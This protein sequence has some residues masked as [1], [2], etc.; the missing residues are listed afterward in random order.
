M[1]V[2]Q[3]ISLTMLRAY[4]LTQVPESKT[5]VFE[6]RNE[7]EDDR[8]RS[9]LGPR[10]RF[11]DEHTREDRTRVSR[12]ALS[13]LQTHLALSRIA[14]TG[15]GVFLWL[16]I[17][18]FFEQ[19]FGTKYTI[20]QTA[21][22]YLLSQT[23]TC[24]TAPLA[25]ESVRAGLNRTVAWSICCLVAALLFLAG[26]LGGYFGPML[27]GGLIGFAILYGVFSAL[28]WLPYTAGERSDLADLAGI[29]V[30]I[31]PFIVGLW[32]SVG[33][34]EAPRIL[35]GAAAIAALSLMPLT[36]LSEVKEFFPW[37][38]RETFGE[39]FD[40]T[41]RRMVTLSFADG[42]ESA[43]FFFVW[44][45]VIFELFWD[46]FSLVGA[47]ASIL[48]IIV[49]ALRVVFREWHKPRLFES[50][51]PSRILIGVSS[52]VLR[53]SAVSFFTIILVDIYGSMSSDKKLYS[54]FDR[55]SRADGGYYLD[56]R[57]L[58]KELAT[59][60]GRIVAI[61]LFW[62]LLNAFTI[63]TSVILMFLFGALVSIL[64][65]SSGGAE[66]PFV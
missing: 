56:H 10:R 2:P 24:L 1:R 61:V 20:E 65:F 60:L 59:T 36:R 8:Y 33:F 9:T 37:D 25:G 53:L 31:M 41:R 66:E 52:W 23:I 21:M 42:V 30:G 11:A 47:A 64:M 40:H 19:R 6:S 16:L 34:S 28:Y 62:M 12:W 5:R 32:L 49:P 48:L 46:S 4:P 54:Q 58:L 51:R 57:T 38:Y 26:S 17:V 44:P 18:Y 50:S 43:L 45:I 3:S 15:V 55:E 22:L 13:P 29:F 7:P 35:L 63:W 27:H 14:R 39:L